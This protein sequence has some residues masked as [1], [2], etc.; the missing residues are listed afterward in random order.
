MDWRILSTIA[1]AAVIVAT[2][3]WGLVVML[4]EIAQQKADAD[5]Q[6][7]SSVDSRDRW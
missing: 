6:D 7:D 5:I 3:T 1:A 4:S 2:A